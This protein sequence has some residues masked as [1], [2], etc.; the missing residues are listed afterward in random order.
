MHDLD[1]HDDWMTSD[2][3]ITD[4][5]GS[6]HNDWPLTAAGPVEHALAYWGPD[7]DPTGLVLI[8]E[9]LIRLDR[10]PLTHA[11]LDLLW[12]APGDS[13][14]GSPTF[15]GAPRAWLDQLLA[16]LGPLAQTRGAEESLWTTPTTCMPNGT[17]P[18]AQ[19]RQRLAPQVLDLTGLLDGARASRQG[20]SFTAT[21]TA[22]ESY[23]SKVCPELAFRFLLHALDRFDC[24]LST[25][26]YSRLE[27]V[28]KGFRYGPYVVDAHRLVDPASSDVNRQQ[29]K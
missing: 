15:G 19:E 7:T 23:A 10:S 8:L 13:L 14:G 3:G 2:F 9:D 11:E 16:A 25:E 26:D 27:E 20:E 6:Y 22:I 28:G 18:S 5:C 12:Q 21:R 24:S 4:L 17:E 29:Q 1:L